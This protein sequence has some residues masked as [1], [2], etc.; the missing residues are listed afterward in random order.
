MAKFPVEISDPEGIVDAV[1]N[2]LSGPAGLGQNFA[3]YSTYETG[4]LTGNFR[5]PFTYT[6]PALIYVPPIALSTSEMLDDRT[7]KFTFNVAQPSVP[8]S[9]GMPITVNG[10]T[11][12][13]YDG[14]YTP[15]G[16]V[17]C[18]TTYVIVRTQTS[19][20]IVAPSTGGNVY[21]Y[22]TLKDVSETNMSTDANA[23]VTVTGGTD[24]VFIS[25]QLNNVIT[26]EGASGDDLQYTVEISRLKGFIN[27][28]P[29]NPEYRFDF[30]GTVAKHVY[31]FTGLSGS[32]SLDNVE[33]IF[34]AIID[35]PAP[36]YYWYLLEVRFN[37]PNWDGTG[38]LP[39]FQVT[40]CEFTQR[41]LSAQV[42]K[43]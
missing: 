38:A 15:I 24:R 16:V 37:N 43:Q 39:T 41:G 18:T 2:L 8:F 12:P 34:T 10:V 40:E 14:D 27:S 7:W 36:A 42:V 33:T 4:Y 25:A 31:N 5:P 35:Q 32:G 17:E 22:N 6:V 3:G 21:Y 9:N 28:D 19:Y 29:V 1:N 23:K 11:D 26:Y 30:D 20:D 13:Y